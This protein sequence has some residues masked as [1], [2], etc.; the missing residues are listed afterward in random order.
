MSAFIEYIKNIAIFLIFS[1][2]VMVIIPNSKYKNYINLALGFVMIFLVISPIQSLLSGSENFLAGGFI[3]KF[4]SVP[5]IQNYDDFSKYDDERKAMIISAYKSNLNDS[6]KA[7]VNSGGN[8]IYVNSDFVVGESEENFGQILQLHLEV[9]KRPPDEISVNPSVTPKPFIRIEPI[10][11]NPN[12]I[13]SIFQKSADESGDN[14]DI[15]EAQESPEI[16]NLKNLLLDFY[17][18]SNDNINIIVLMKNR[19]D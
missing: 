15:A 7:I 16:K 4:S 12:D 14:A 6:L 8:F 10:E 11:V 5:G 3:N 1:T 9:D 13:F 17:N 18:L 2:F 19:G